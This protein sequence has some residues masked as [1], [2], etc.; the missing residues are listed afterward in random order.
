MAIDLNNT[1]PSAPSG[2]VNGQWQADSSEPRH[3]SVHVQL[4]V[5]IVAISTTGTVAAGAVE[6][7]EL[8]T[9]SS[10]N[11]TR[12]LPAVSTSTNVI[13]VIKKIDS[14]SGSVIVDGNASETIDGGLTYTLVN[15][16]QYV[17][18]HCDGSAWYVTGGN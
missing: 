8:V 12:T 17:R 5:S 15:Q 1:T 6:T 18:L 14:G 3:I 4:P 16:Y 13:L 11:K 9:T 2:R 7:V 10:S